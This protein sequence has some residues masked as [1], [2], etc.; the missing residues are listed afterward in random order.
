MT[1]PSSSTVHLIREIY[2]T[3]ML[4]RPRYIVKMIRRVIFLLTL[5][6]VMWGLTLVVITAALIYGD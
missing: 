5:M 4:F 6:L 1:Q 2:A 3:L